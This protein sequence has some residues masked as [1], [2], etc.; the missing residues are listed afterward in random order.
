M[1]SRNQLYNALQRLQWLAEINYT[2]LYNDFNDEP[3][4]V[5][6]TTTSMASRNQLYNA[7]QRPKWLAEIN[8][9]TPYNDF[10]G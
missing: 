7:L 1:A 2:T 4:S 10:N 3:K 9:T 6:F 8:Y 5:S